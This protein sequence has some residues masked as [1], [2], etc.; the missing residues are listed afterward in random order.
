TAH[1]TG[2]QALLGSALAYPS[3][4]DA[5]R[6]NPVFDRAP[7]L[8]GFRPA[9]ARDGNCLA[10]LPHPAT[11]TG[12]PGTGAATHPWPPALAHAL[13]PARWQSHRP[14]SA[15]PAAS[16]VSLAET[17]PTYRATCRRYTLPPPAPAA[18]DRTRP[19]VAAGPRS[20]SA[21]PWN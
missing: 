6:R 10:P 11:P 9:Q 15:A 7:T 16:T 1:A 12:A 4:R 17:L 14:A 21:R 18:T 8:A 13:V 5:D 20:F 2:A 3:R 19:P